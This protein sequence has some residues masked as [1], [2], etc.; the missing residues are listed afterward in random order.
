MKPFLPFLRIDELLKQAST[1]A[2]VPCWPS[3]YF[4]FTTLPRHEGLHFAEY[5]P[6][7][8]IIPVAGYLGGRPHSPPAGA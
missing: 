1:D 4:Y 5:P 3:S 6:G 8:Q 2:A 7:W